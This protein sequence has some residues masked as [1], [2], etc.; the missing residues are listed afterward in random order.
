[1]VCFLFVEKEM[2]DIKLL[3]DCCIIST[4]DID[5][6]EDEDSEDGPPALKWSSH[7]VRGT[8]L[9][10]NHKIFHY[11]LPTPLLDQLRRARNPTC[12]PNTSVISPLLALKL[13]QKFLE[14]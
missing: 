6:A 3:L 10:K 2:I 13:L 5:A 4:S 7:M 14:S 1:M 11:G 8:W 9:S 12:Q